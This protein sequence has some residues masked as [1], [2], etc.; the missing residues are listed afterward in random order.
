MKLGSAAVIA[1]A[2]AA[3]GGLGLPFG[4]SHVQ[5]RP[6][7]EPVVDPDEHPPLPPASGTPIGF[8]VDDAGEL[9]LSDDQLSKLR[10]LN[11]DLAGK[12]AVDD[13]GMI[14]E[15]VAPAKKQDPNKGRGLGFRASGGN[16]SVA[17]GGGG[18]PNAGVGGSTENGPTTTTMVIP[19]E[20]VTRVY[21]SRAKHI[22]EAIASAMKL[23]DHKQ[24]EVADR[25]LVDHGVDPETGEVKGGEP[26]QQKLEAPK[27]GQ[28][29]PRE[30]DQ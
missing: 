24:Q 7:A 21:R 23:L 13:S 16:D 1:V 11:D 17:G 18:F 19:A 6:P 28:P 8:L 15:P 29:L 9:K 10:A 26:G 3:S 5:S 22:R 4:C 20:V 2:L 14:A 25:V 27:P 12:L 30:K